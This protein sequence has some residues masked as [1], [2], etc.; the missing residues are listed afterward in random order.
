MRKVQYYNV[1]LWFFNIIVDVQNN[2]DQY[3][4][5]VTTNGPIL[6]WNLNLA[7]P[8]MTRRERGGR[9]ILTMTEGG[10]ATRLG[11]SLVTSEIR[12]D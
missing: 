12:I 8:Y 5:Y 2:R 10:A 11:L 1:A 4:V 7:A 9:G 3:K 6:Y